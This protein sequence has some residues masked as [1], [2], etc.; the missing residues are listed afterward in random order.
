[1]WFIA[2]ASWP[3]YIVC[4]LL[5]LHLGLR[6]LY[7]I[8]CPRFFGIHLLYVVYFPFFFA[9]V[10]CMWFT[11][12]P[13]WPLSIVC[14]LLTLGFGLCRTRGEGPVHGPYKAQ[15]IICFGL[16]KATAAGLEIKYISCLTK[17]AATTLMFTFIIVYD[18][19]M[20]LNVSKWP[21][22][23]KANQI[24]IPV[25]MYTKSCSCILSSMNTFKCRKHE[26][27]ACKRT[28]ENATLM[29]L[30]V[31]EIGVNTRSD[32]PRRI[33]K[34]YKANHNSLTRSGRHAVLQGIN[35]L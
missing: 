22:V 29:S 6:L 18:P 26:L 11:A 16:I 33:C 21:L 3:S 9:S 34:E 15:E 20:I 28:R 27:H 32:N 2:L 8:Y 4:G 19:R 30:A 31:G 1:M 14:A 24:L 25:L 35:H 23:E 12:L 7:M 5:P 13:S 10:Y 17:D